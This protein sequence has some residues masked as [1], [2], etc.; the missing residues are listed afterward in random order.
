MW[1]QHS[2]MFVLAGLLKLVHD[3]VMFLGPF[4]LEQLLK[5]LQRGGTI[6]KSGPPAK[7]CRMIPWGAYCGQAL[8]GSH[9]LPR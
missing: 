1:R 6:C 8:Y 3:V 5:Y 7:C 2:R 4:V 9:L